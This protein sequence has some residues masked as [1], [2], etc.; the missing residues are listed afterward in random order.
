MQRRLL[1]LA[2]E[3]AIAGGAV[4]LATAAGALAAANPTTVALLLFT[5]VLF[6]AAWRGVAAGVA[7]SVLATACLNFFFLPPLHTWSVEHPENWVALGCFLVASILAGRLVARARRD[8]AAA[9]ARRRE[10][11]ALYRLSVELF[12]TGGLAE[13]AERALGAVGA[14]GGGVVLFEGSPYRQRIVAWSGPLP[15][16]IEDLVAAPARHRRAFEFPAPFGSVGRDVYLP[17]LAGGQAVGVFVARGTE[18]AA[19]ALESVGALLALAV[20]RERTFREQAH[21]EALR[22]SDAL[23]TSLLRAVSHDLTTPLTAIAL[24]TGQLRRQATPAALPL[25]EA[26]EAEADRLRR[27]IQGLL[28]MARLDAGAVVPSLEPTPPADLFRAARESLSLVA[29]ARP[30]EVRVDPDCPDLEVDPALALEVVVNLVENAHRASPP[31]EPV[32]LR[33]RRHPTNAGRVR[34]EVLDRGPGIPLLGSPDRPEA[35]AEPGP[36]ARRG[37]GLEIAQGLAQA[38]QGTVTLAN[39]AGGGAAA[40]LDLPAAALQAGGEP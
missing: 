7:A 32:T 35:A 13:A 21:V 36:D 40:H 12:R 23:K 19:G 28:A 27:R 2:R 25:V 14:R 11:E 39:R 33:A 5:L 37:L 4:A 1:R 26:L 31:G 6:L 29:R 24:Q 20:E 30:I 8:A 10:I 34:L 9:E 18:A 15:G 38:I 17:L 3:L 22:E 16:A